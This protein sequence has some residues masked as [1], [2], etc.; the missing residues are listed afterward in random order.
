MPIQWREMFPLLSYDV[1]RLSLTHRR[2]LSYDTR[3]SLSPARIK[4]LSHKRVGQTVG[5]ALII[6]SLRQRDKTEW[7]MCGNELN[8]WHIWPAIITHLRMQTLVKCI[9][10]LSFPQIIHAIYSHLCMQ[11]SVR[12]MWT[13]NCDNSL[14]NWG[15][16]RIISAMSFSVGFSFWMMCWSARKSWNWSR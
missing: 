1:C 11:T 14:W 13:A 16:A 2:P 15:N 12:C 7:R 4:E 10:T 5:H 9:W 6:T 3:A 8:H